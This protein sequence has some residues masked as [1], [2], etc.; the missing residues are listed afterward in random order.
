MSDM[1]RAASALVE[2]RVESFESL[3]S[4]EESRVRLAAALE[5]QGI[6][7]D[8]RIDLRWSER[9]GRAH[10]DA[11]FRPPR[12]V[13]TVLRLMSITLLLLVIASV[14]QVMTTTE[15]AARF[16]LPLATVLGVLALPFVTLAW[17]SQRDAR[18]SRIRRAIR[19]ALLDAHEKLP[20]PQ[21]WPDED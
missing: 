11:E 12:H 1:K 8:D 18:E 3:H 10:L 4:P 2:L 21:R 13:H 15:G 19:I 17:H 14:H 7:L 6:D 9:E 20:A 16:L 5:R